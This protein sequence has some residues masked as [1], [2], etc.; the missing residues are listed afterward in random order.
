MLRKLTGP[1]AWTISARA[2]MGMPW[3]KIV[4]PD[5]LPIDDWRRARAM[6]EGTIVE[7]STH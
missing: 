4:N 6:R 1:R 3:I 5:C 7:A 2:R